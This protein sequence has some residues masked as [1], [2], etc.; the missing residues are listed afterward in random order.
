MPTIGGFSIVR[1]MRQIVLIAHNVRSCL[2][3][4][5]LLRTSE[6]LAVETVYLTGYTPYPNSADDDRLPHLARKNDAEIHKSA[7]GAE[8]MISWKHNSS[9]EPVIEE[10][11]SAGYIIVA[12]EQQDGA[13]SLP[14][15]QPA[16]KMALIVGREVEGIENE[17]LAQCDAVLQIPMLGRKESFNVSAAA[18]MSLYHL[19]FTL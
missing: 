16:Y 7:L 8:D 11:R 19:T 9:I 10:L 13:I 18:A 5:S 6:G 4:G 2:N 17:I 1:D 14:S 3:V 15:F 12:L